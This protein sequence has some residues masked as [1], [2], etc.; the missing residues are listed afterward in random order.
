MTQ[1]YTEDDIRRILDIRCDEEDVEMSSDA[2]ALLTKIGVETS[3]RY[4]INLIT[5]AAL[6]CQK[7]KGR[8]VEIDDNSRVLR[9]LPQWEAVDTVP[10]GVPESIHVQ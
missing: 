3:L 4:T 9:A 8:V 5:S 10:G 1:P 6:A 7:R 2:K